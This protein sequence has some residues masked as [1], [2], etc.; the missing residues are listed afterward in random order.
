MSNRPKK[1]ITFDGGYGRIGTIEVVETDCNICGKETKCFYIDDSQEEYAGGAVCLDCA[2]EQL[3][4]KPKCS[5]G[6]MQ[7]MAEKRVIELS[8]NNIEATKTVFAVKPGETVEALL[9]RVGID[10]HVPWHYDQVEVR[11]KLVMP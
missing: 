9:T 5:E 6:K 11:L 10:G 3:T 4:E 1:I 8:E 2:I 7:I